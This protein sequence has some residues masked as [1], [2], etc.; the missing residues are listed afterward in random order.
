[1]SVYHHTLL[2]VLI[3]FFLLIRLT[4]KLS[5]EK[6]ENKSLTRAMEYCMHCELA[7]P[8]DLH[9]LLAMLPGRDDG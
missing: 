7:I 5:P 8:A 3:Q 6:A 1:M 2:E 9:C 4:H